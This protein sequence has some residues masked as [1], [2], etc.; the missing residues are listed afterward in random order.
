MPMLKA[1]KKGRYNFFNKNGK[2]DENAG[3]GFN[4]NEKYR[5]KN[6]KA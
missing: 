1:V 4:K 2:D 5:Y 3:T 6:C